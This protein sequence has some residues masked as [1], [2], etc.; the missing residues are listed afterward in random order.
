MV[1]IDKLK[2]LYGNNIEYFG[3]GVHHIMVSRD[4]N[5]Y[6]YK[7]NIRELG[8]YRIKEVMGKVIVAESYMH[9][10]MTYIINAETDGFLSVER[11]MNY[12]TKGYIIVGY[13]GIIAVIDKEYNIIEYKIDSK[14]I[15]LHGGYLEGDSEVKVLHRGCIEIRYIYI[16][17]YSEYDNICY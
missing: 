5:Y 9:P 13:R 16:K 1:N 10:N 15:K 17:V 8:S 2:M 4:K 11:V 3:Y 6:C 12:T 7:N 14:E